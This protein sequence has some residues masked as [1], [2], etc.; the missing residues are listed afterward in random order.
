MLVG[1][2]AHILE[3]VRGILVDTGCVW[4]KKALA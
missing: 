1:H 2:V 3:E 4:D